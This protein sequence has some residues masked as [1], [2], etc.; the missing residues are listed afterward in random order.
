M[1]RQDR[2]DRRRRAAT[3]LR[4]WLDDDTCIVEYPSEE[5]RVSGA[6]YLPGELVFATALAP[7]RWTCHLPERGVMPLQYVDRRLVGLRSALRTSEALGRTLRATFFIPEQR[8]E[9]EAINR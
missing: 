2:Q 8:V 5:V 6:L 9:L 4:H 3:A 7:P 1:E